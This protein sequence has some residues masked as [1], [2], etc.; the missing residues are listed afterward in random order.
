[1]D[2]I[3]RDKIKMENFDFRSKNPDS[4]KLTNIALNYEDKYFK[5]M[6]ME[7]EAIKNNYMI[8]LKKGDKF[9][10]TN[11]GDP[12]FITIADWK[13]I[14]KDTLDCEGKCDCKKLEILIKKGLSPKDKKTTIL[15]EM[16]HAY[17]E[18]LQLSQQGKPREIVFLY[19]H[20]III[21]RLGIKNTNKLLKQ[22]Q[23]SL[24][25]VDDHSILFT[26]KSLELDL[27]LKLPFGSIFAY[28]KTDWFPNIKY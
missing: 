8:Y 22:A 21:K 28:G 18:E 16:I 10:K 26:M 20:N 17:E 6:T 11:L 19:I 7:L 14:E 4:Y 24:F 9:V 2:N 25:W 5:D 1:M 23:S 12:P 13:I 3:N 15:H 27:R